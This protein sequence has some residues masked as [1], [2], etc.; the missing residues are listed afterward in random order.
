MKSAERSSA[1]FRGLVIITMC[2]LSHLILAWPAA[3]SYIGLDA[4]NNVVIL[5]DQGRSINVN[6]VDL[7]LAIQRLEA[8]NAAQN[9][10]IS[11]LQVELSNAWDSQSEFLT[12]ILC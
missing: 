7:L 10:T 5:G 2:L 6:G 3:A 8:I 12:M 11:R 4:E 1:P 9:E